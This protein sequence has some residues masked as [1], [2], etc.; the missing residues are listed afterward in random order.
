M[1]AQGPFQG[2]YRAPNGI[3][4]KVTG[5][6]EP[7]LLLHG[8]LV[9]GAMFDPLLT[10]L[11]SSFCMIIPD[12]RGHGKSGDLSG[13][14]DVPAL[15]ADL[16]SVLKQ[17]GFESCAVLGYSHG[18]AVAQ[19]LAH[20]RPALVNKMM[21]TC[22]YAHNLATVRERVEGSVFL[23][24]LTF[25]TPATIAK[26]LVRSPKPKPAGELGLNKTQADWLQALM[27]S[28]RAAAMR[29]AVR[30]MMTFD[31]RPWLGEVRAPTLVVG[32][33]DDAAVPRHHFDQLVNG[34]PRA[35]GQ[36]V[37]RAGHALMWTHT[38]ELA[39]IVQT[40]W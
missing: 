6:G 22:T 24:L 30:G 8:L 36:M 13:P 2:E 37:A 39:E 21:L 29:G 40:N 26:L 1:P 3:F 20:T 28:N 12:L 16:D 14:Y 34:I 5:N 38:R 27:A 35:R 11:Q 17:A 19:Q 25:F 33:S 7:L 4:Y 10:L 18:G 9:S 23:T 31:S 32:G 15:A